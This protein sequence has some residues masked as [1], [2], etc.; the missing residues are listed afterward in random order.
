MAKN[1]LLGIDF[2]SDSVR[3]LVVDGADGREVATAVRYYP[4]WKEGLYSDPSENRY[5]HHPLDYI[6]S[7]EGAIQEALTLAGT[8]VA[9]AVRGISF[10]T[11]AST[12]VLVDREGTPLSLRPE[13]AENPDAMFVLW[14]DHTA[15][16]EA[17][18]I[19][20]LAKR[21]SSDYT[22]FCG[23]TY[24]CEWVWAK[25]LHCLKNSP[26]LVGEAWSWVELCDW[27]SALLTGNTLP[28]EIKRSRCAA[29]H[30]AMWNAK[31]GGLPE[32]EFFA[33]VD[34][35]LAELYSHLYTQT[36][37]CGTPAGVISA[38]WAERLGLPKDVVIGVAAID[39]HI[40]AVG[41]GVSEG[42]LVKV[43]G[44][45]TCDIT[46]ARAEK[47]ADRTIRGICGQVNGSVLPDYIGIE[48]GQSAF[49][50]IYAWFRRIMEWPLRHIANA[51]PA[52]FD[53]ILPVLTAEAEALPL[54]EN[55]PVA[56]DWFNGRRSPDDDP[57]ATGSF[58][59]LT[60]ATTAPQLF[61][62]LVE[63]TAFGSRAIT[64]RLIEEGVAVERIYAVGGISKKSKFVMQTLCD[65]L[66]MPISVV[67]SEQA[68]ALGS[69]MYAA[70]AAGLYPSIK[71][72]QEAMLSGF[73]DEYYPNPERG[74]IY[75]KLYQRYKA[76]GRD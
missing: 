44:T 54:T 14:K 11:T 55:D 49:G 40:G 4:R 50:D 22:Q 63:A 66:K 58:A 24:S 39:C 6:T 57:R 8:E 5:R 70:V 27:I 76:A 71:E 69:A 31:W 34:P 59:G 23:G 33:A 10:D 17:D 3:C 61:K 30:K 68:C 16:K 18:A 64:E 15:L 2:G 36:Y 32:R 48:A 29:G 73:S 38:E 21:W 45:S 20:T 37:P 7:L 43:V 62:T 47:V 72:A 42:T 26:E 25:V 1:Y 56:V 12:P 28:E 67:R 74:K 75:D 51:D 41:A 13:F 9:A 35:L 65:V 46:V 60:L 53:K 19:N 52:I